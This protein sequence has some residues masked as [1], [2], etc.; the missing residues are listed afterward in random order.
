[1]CVI[2]QAAM[3]SG[4]GAQCS[5]P[6]KTKKV[7]QEETPQPDPFTR[8]REAHSRLK[9]E[10]AIYREKLAPKLENIQSARRWWRS[11][12]WIPPTW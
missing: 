7:P 4:L 12:R 6:M 3:S 10:L 11:R 8:H 1:L 2:F 9:E 5:T